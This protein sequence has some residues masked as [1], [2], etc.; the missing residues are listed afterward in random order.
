MPPPSAA[1]PA[2]AL[3]EARARLEDL[4]RQEGALAA[5]VREERQQREDLQVRLAAVARATKPRA[6]RG[7]RHAQPLD[8]ARTPASRRLADDLATPAD[9]E[10]S[11][12]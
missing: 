12:A 11:E 7:S 10:L 5:R 4:E 1:P 9:R 3:A 8:R 6:P 2:E